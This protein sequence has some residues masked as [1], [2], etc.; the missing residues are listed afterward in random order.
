MKQPDRQASGT[1]KAIGRVAY[2]HVRDAKISGN[3]PIGEEKQF[4]ELSRG[5]IVIELCYPWRPTARPSEFSQLRIRVYG[6]KVF[7]IRWE[8][9]AS[10]SSITSRATGSGRCARWTRIKPRATSTSR[11]P[12]GPQ[13]RKRPPYKA[14]FFRDRSL[15]ISPSVAVR[16]QPSWLKIVPAFSENHHYGSATPF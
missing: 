16:A 9:A 10:R 5:G 11:P 8:T 15:K 13:F 2:R 12:K 7:E 6:E 3:I 1:R 14:A 4:R